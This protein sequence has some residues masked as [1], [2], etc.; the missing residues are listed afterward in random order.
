[1]IGEHRV[2]SVAKGELFLLRRTGVLAVIPS[3]A[4]RELRA[5]AQRI[6]PIDG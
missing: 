5:W 6:R 4:G 2:V 3:K 1:M